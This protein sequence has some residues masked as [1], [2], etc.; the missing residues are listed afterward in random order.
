MTPSDVKATL[1][2]SDNSPSVEMPIYKGT[3]GPDVIDI[4]KLY[5]Q[6]GKFTYDPGFMSTAACNSAITYIDGDK[7]EL[8]YRGYPIDKLAQN[9]DFLETCYLLLKGELPN[10]EQNDEF[11]KT[12][13][14]HTMVHE[15]MHFF[16]RGFRRDAHPMAMLVAAVGALSAFYH[17][18]LD[19]NDP[20]HREDLGHPPDREAADAGRD[21]VQVQRSA[22]RSCTRR[23]TCRT[24]RTS[25]T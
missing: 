16:F 7:G 9:A 3:I 14:H 2:F 15:Q 17:D 18:S 22:S 20:R 25:C 13:T 23:T 4:R 8:L 21:G 1:S 11:V 12:V 5:G 24:A 6:T 19:I 10:A